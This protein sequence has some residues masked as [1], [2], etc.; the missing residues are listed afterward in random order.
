[1]FGAIGSVVLKV[2]TAEDNIKRE[3]TITVISPHRKASHLSSSG[4]GG[5]CQSSGRPL[6]AAVQ[7]MF[8]SI[9]YMDK[10]VTPRAHLKHR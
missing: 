6:T 4:R 10:G 5:R 2:K 8:L 3:K 9:V 1:M 7:K